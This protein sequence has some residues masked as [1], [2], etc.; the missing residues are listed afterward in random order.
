MSQE[1]LSHRSSFRSDSDTEEPAF[2]S[3]VV[4]YKDSVDKSALKAL[5]RQSEGPLI[6]LAL[7][8]MADI[9]INN[10]AG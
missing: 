5:N 3:V 10:I 7:T 6:G 1:Q 2:I 8:I 4:I 9:T